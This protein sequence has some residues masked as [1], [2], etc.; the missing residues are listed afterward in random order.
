MVGG[1][2]MVEADLVDGH[3]VDLRART[4]WLQVFGWL[5]AFYIGTA[6]LNF[7]VGATLGMLMA[8]NPNWWGVLAPLHGELNPYGWLTLLIY[9][10]TYA[11]LKWFASIVSPWPKLGWIQLLVAETGVLSIVLA[12]LIASFELLRIGM[13]LQA[14]APILFLINILGSVSAKHRSHGERMPSPISELVGLNFFSATG[15]RVSEPARRM[16]AALGDTSRRFETDSVGQRGTDLALMIFVCCAVWVSVSSWFAPSL[17][18]YVCPP[19]AT[20]LTF[21]GWIAGTVLSVSV[22]LYQRYAGES[23]LK[24]RPVQMGQGLWVLG[25]LLATVGYI[26]SSNMMISIGSRLLGIGFLWIGVLYLVPI[27]RVFPGYT[28]PAH[29]AWKLSSF[30]LSLLGVGFTIGMPLLSVAMFHLM[31]LG[32]ITMLVYG[33]GYTFFPLLLRRNPRSQRLA[34]IQVWL[35]LIGVMLMFNGFYC[36]EKGFI[37]GLVDLFLAVGGV[38]AATSALYFLIQW[39]CGDK[40]NIW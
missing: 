36:M 13:L 22:H 21:Y 24:K 30:C 18:V 37:P 27:H 11:V 5:P 20:V 31:F 34:N 16:Y 33:V 9:G 8:L 29:I 4:E 32:W 28:H 12:Y 40:I 2:E 10:M 14:L 35:G 15:L 3:T 19:G 38:C 39:P 17:S 25:L 23:C 26:L 1:E 7:A 6:F